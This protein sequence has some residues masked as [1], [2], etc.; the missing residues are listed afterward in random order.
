MAILPDNI[1]PVVCIAGPTASGK[2]GW[3]IELAQTVDGEIINADSMQVYKSLHIIT[4]RPSK[5]EMASIPH[6]LFGHVDVTEQYSTGRWV[7]EARE[8]IIDCLA[9]QKTPILVGGTGLY[10]KALTVGLANIP[11]PNDQILRQLNDYS[12]IDLRIKA[13]EVDPIAA[14][15]VL[16]DDRQRLLRLVSVALG[17][18]KKLSEWHFETKPEIPKPYWVGAALLPDREKLYQRIDARFEQ[19]MANGG[20][21]EVKLLNMMELDKGLTVLKAIG[22]PPFVEYLSG[23]ISYD[24]ALSRAKRDTRRYAKR[25]FT[26]LRGQARDWFCVKN[27]N[28]KGDFEQ[29][30]SNFYV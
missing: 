23:K 20:L 9:R 3:A 27:S 19:M 12:T 2:S 14:A 5:V 8:Q 6:H 11:Q 16:G 21:D 18:K 29:K 10:F 1:K 4:A 13:E 24:E 30:I 17:T 22:V 15:R 26:W 28:D 7:R 25:Q